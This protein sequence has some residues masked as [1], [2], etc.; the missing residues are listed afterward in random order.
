M[1]FHRLAAA[2][3]AAALSFGVPAAQAET[4]TDDAGRTVE[5]Q[6]PVKRAVIFNRYAVE[7]AR[8]IGGI[9]QVAGVDASTMRDPTYWPQ[10]KESDIV[11]QGQTQPNYEAI[12]A[13][14]PDVVILPRNGVYEE[15]ARQLEPFGIPVLVVTAWDTLQHVPNVTTFGT[16]FGKQQ[17]ADKLNAFYTRYMDLLKDRLKGV[18][19]KRVYLEEVRDLV[20]LT[21]GSGWHDMIEAGGGINVFG[22]IDIKQQPSSRGNENSFTIDPEEIVSRKP[23]V[24]IKLQPG[25]YQTIPTAKFEDAWKA[26]VV[27][28]EVLATPAGKSGD[29]HLVNYYLAGGCSKVIGALQVAKWLYPDQFKDIEPEAV[30]KEWI[31]TFQGLPFHGDT[32]YQGKI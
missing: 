6:T 12:V 27:R 28:E 21:P 24:I 26:L 5:V 11:G 19:R 13:M 30:M 17:E 32:T 22:D 10:F 20:T 29:V 7:F 4:F 8:A 3:L 15:A 9:E 14:K 18:E 25:S 31:E 16:L 1:K 2:F 23:D